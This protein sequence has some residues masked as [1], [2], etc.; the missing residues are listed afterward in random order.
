MS[1]K[2]VVTDTFKKYGKRLA[3]KYP[4]LTS[5][6]TK[7]VNI[8]EINPIQGKPLGKDC[9]KIRLSI[10]SKGK[11]KSGGSRVVTCVKISNQ[12]AYLLTIYDKSGKE[13]ISDKELNDLLCLAGLV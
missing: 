8:L 13:T 12:T 2:V 10:T 4:S 6:L 5:D 7:L 11:G 3:K 1:F 9:Y